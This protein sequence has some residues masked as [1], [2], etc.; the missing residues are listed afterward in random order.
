MFNLLLLFHRSDA[1]DSTAG[2]KS[3]SQSQVFSAKKHPGSE[4]RDTR[5]IKPTGSGTNDRK[6]S[7]KI[8]GLRRSHQESCLEQFLGLFF[9][10]GSYYTGFSIRHFCERIVSPFFLHDI[11]TLLL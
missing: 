5:I 6:Y 10:G 2:T 4:E 11:L 9:K 8:A 3:V 1:A 7:A